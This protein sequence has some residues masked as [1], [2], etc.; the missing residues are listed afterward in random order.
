MPS[1]PRTHQLELSLFYHVMNRGNYRAEIFH[2]EKDYLY[3]LKILQDYS[4]EN[5]IF[6]YHWALMPTHYHLLLEIN[7]PPKL[8]KIMAGIA[9]SYVHYHHR[10]YESAGHLWQG[11][12]KSQPIQKERYLLSCGRYIER[13]PVKAG[14]A[15]HPE[16]YPYSSARYYIHHEQDNLT[17]KDPLIETFGR[18]AEEQTKGYKT[19][20]GNFDTQEEN[21]FER[22]EFPLGSPEFRHKLLREKGLFV[23]KRR[24]GR[25][26][27][28][29]RI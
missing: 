9:R 13:N 16:D 12:F 5:S 15:Q 27:V 20:L 2:G 4:R 1:V 6:V 7:E 10:T 29:A 25:P 28:N 24:I 8:S 11:R 3:F 21:Q 14:L 19:F 18:D 17:T 22:F 26:K 23:P